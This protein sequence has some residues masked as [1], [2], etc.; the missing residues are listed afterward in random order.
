MYR[1]SPEG[2]VLLANTALVSMLGYK[3]FDELSRRDLASEGYEPRYPRLEFQD[4]IEK[5]GEVRGLESAWKRKDGSIIFVRE[6]ARLVRDENNQPMYYEGTVEDITQRK[7]AE[8]ALRQSE[9]ELRALFASMNDVVMVIDSEGIY[10]KFAPTNPGLLIKPPEELLGKPLSEVFP[11]EQAKTYIN[12][13]KKVTETKQPVQI[14][15]DLPIGGRIV[16]FEASIAPL[17]DDSTLWVARD[18]TARKLAEEK[19]NQLNAELEKRVEERTRELQQAQDI[20]VRQ[21]K[22]AVLGQLAGGVGHE[23]RNPLGIIS[24]AIYYLKLIQPDAAEKVKEYQAL[25]SREVRAS[26][27]IITDL[28]DFARLESMER[29]QVAVTEL[30]QWTLMRF[31]VPEFIETTLKLPEDLPDVLVD[32][33]Q[34]QQVL[35]NLVVNASQ[36]IAPE[37]QSS[38]RSKRG[39]ITISARRIKEMVAIAVK[40]TGAGITPENM[41]RIFE[42]LFTTKSKGIGLGLAVSRKLAEANGGRIEVKSE[43]GKGSTFTLFLP[44]HAD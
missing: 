18:I 42:P 31:A 16:K 30:V 34:M 44:V 7:K 17:A 1:T 37:G 33:G 39:R 5:D 40:D 13:L 23:L 2:Q 9:A 4:L 27:K 29:S 14:D 11:L 12:V 19:V 41:N 15:Y 28:L 22:L 20:M 21:E 25:I 3:T 8:D 26:E 43:L 38:G 35:G 24:N 32:L 10:R 36:A 6:S